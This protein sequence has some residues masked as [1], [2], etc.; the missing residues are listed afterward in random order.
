MGKQME[1]R[2]M[3][4]EKFAS[5]SVVDRNRW[6]SWTWFCQLQITCHKSQ[7]VWR[8]CGQSCLQKFTH[9]L[10]HSLGWPL[11]A[12]AA[13]QTRTFTS[14]AKTRCNFHC[15]ALTLGLLAKSKLTNC[16]ASRENSH[17]VCIY[18]TQWRA[19]CLLA[20]TISDV[21]SG[22]TCANVVVGVEYCVRCPAFQS[23]HHLPLSPL[24]L[25]HPLAA[26]LCNKHMT[27][28]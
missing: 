7:L 16:A 19:Q 6:M 13:V 12:V 18:S 15:L 2:S 11:V 20:A 3:K 23:Q 25:L 14:N 10:T 22:S 4:S 1:K 26:R 9:S 5:G 24:S 27:I 28:N 17:A 21:S 8:W